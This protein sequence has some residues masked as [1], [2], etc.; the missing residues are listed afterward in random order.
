MAKTKVIISGPTETKDA[1]LDPKGTTF[2]RGSVCDVILDDAAV[3]RCHARISQDPF[4]RW[5][6]EDTD[7]QNGVFIEGRRIKAQAILPN[8]KISIRPFTLSI[9]QESEQQI[10]PGTED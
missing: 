10:V 1:C 3:S 2:G 8:Q 4:G 6:V 7:S 9:W 5:I